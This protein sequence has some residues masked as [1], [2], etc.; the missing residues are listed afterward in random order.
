MPYRS[1]ARPRSLQFK[2]RSNR[3]NRKLKNTV[4]Q[5]SNAKRH[6]YQAT[7]DIVVVGYPALAAGEY[8]GFTLARFRRTFSGATDDTVDT[9]TQSNNYQTPDVMNQ[10]SISNHQAKFTIRNR[11]GIGGTLSVY[12]VALSF[13][14]AH[15]WN[16]K[17]PSFCPV[18]FDS[19]G[20]APDTRGTVSAKAVTTTIITR[21]AYNGFKG[22]QHYLDYLGEIEVP[23]EDAGNGGMVTLDVDGIPPKCKRANEGM[24]YAYF[25]HNDADKNGNETLQLDATVDVSFD[26]TP[27][28]N[29]I[30]WFN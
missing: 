2:G 5:L 1:P 25:F 6:E 19:T 29:R 21:N 11:S 8:F 30:P 4:S 20:T 24:F 3:G 18:T 9:P 10:S 28:D 27:T 7:P 12:R 23:S 26:E 17:H 13:W 15:T 14:D 16:T 22:V